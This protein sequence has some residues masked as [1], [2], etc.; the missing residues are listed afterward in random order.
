[1]IQYQIS[2]DCKWG[3]FDGWSRCSKT[4]GKGT[5]TRSRSIATPAANGGK[6]CE[7]DAREVKTCNELDCPPIPERSMSDLLSIMYLCVS[8]ILLL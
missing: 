8:N 1:M 5:Q 7:G 3:D 6:E 2:V 4:C